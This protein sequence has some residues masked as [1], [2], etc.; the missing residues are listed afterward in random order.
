M[1]PK[2][3]DMSLI[4]DNLN[5]LTLDSTE[6][7]SEFNLFPTNANCPTNPITTTNVGTGRCYAGPSPNT[8]AAPF[9]LNTNFIA[10]STVYIKDTQSISFLTGSTF[11]TD[12]A[13]NFI[14]TLQASVGDT[15]YVNIQNLTAVPLNFVMFNLASFELAA[16][17]IARINMFVTQTGVGY[18]DPVNSFTPNYRVDAVRVF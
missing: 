5:Y 17:S 2:K 8:T 4:Q 7:A 11:N 18:Y 12:S 9:R 6:Y 1:Y 14:K 3:V 10:D 16:G 13:E 15:Y